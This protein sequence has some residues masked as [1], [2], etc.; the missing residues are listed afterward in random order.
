MKE[1]FT[2]KDKLGFFGY[3]IK[4]LFT[5][6]KINRTAEKLGYYTSIDDIPIYNWDKIEQGKFEYLFKTKRGVVP[7]YFTK[8]ISNM[9]Y[10]FEHVNMDI[11]EKKHKLAYL[12]NLY[13]TTKRV[14]FLNKSRHLAAE[15]EKYENKV[16]KKQ[17]LNE[18]INNIESIF[19]SIGSIDPKKMSTSRFYSLLHMAIKKA[20]NIARNGINS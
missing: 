7:E 13:I 4:I 17:T 10:Q 5:H 9:F 1:K 14:D 8:I 11:I 6:V 12:R 19:N 15:I 3:F 2:I 18:K 16:V 20:D